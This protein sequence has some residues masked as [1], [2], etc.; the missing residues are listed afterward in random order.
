[1]NIVK[2]VIWSAIIAA[3]L[4]W[5]IGPLRHE[6]KQLQRWPLAHESRIG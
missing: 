3:M 5:L 6:S 4:V 2:L 1:M